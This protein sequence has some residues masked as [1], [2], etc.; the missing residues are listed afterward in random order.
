MQR[1]IVR[2][3]L[4][5]ELELREVFFGEDTGLHNY[6]VLCHPENAKYPISSVFHD[7]A[8][9]GGN[10]AVPPDTLFRVMDCDHVLTSSEK[11]VKERFNLN[12]KTRPLVFVSGKMGPP[13]QVRKKLIV[14][15]TLGEQGVWERGACVCFFCFVVDCVSLFRHQAMRHNDHKRVGDRKSTER[16]TDVMQ[17]E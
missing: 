16:E 8:Q 9:Q 3:N 10:T 11:T 17:L 12:D 14:E 15:R 13:R 6:A 5:D 7:A 2:V 4:D 1:E